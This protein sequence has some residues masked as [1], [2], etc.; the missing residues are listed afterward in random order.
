M[1]LGPLMLDVADVSLSNEDREVLNHPLVGGVILFARNY[2]SPKQVASL[3][4]EI[5]ALRKTPLLVAVDQEGGRVQRFKDGFTRLP[6]VAD[7]GLIYNKDRSLA[8]QLAEQT[9]WINAAELRE[10]GA[11]LSF[12]PVLDLDFS[13]SSVIGDRAFHR[14]PEVVADLAHSYM[15]GMDQAGMAAVGKHF[16]GHGAIAADSHETISIDERPYNDIRNEDMLAFER[17]IHF[18]M[19]AIMIAHIIYSQCHDQPAGFS[20]YWLKDV[21]RRELDFQGAIFSDDL[22]MKGAAGLGDI[23]DRADACMQAGCDMF[24]VCNDRDAAVKVIDGLKPEVN[25]ASNSRLLRLQ[26]R[27]VADSTPLRESQQWHQAAK[28]VE[29]YGLKETL[30]LDM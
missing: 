21:L 8:C 29:S 19:P 20:G 28:A 6:P 7:L 1:S 16:P 11:D 4:K 30:D 25:P 13:V 5:H 27:N 2:E 24:L 10:V 3:I 12:A 26:G 14:S 18:G 9:G 22:S 17:M 23:V 15:R